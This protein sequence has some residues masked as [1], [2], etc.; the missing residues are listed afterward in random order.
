ML[1]LDQ[2]KDFRSFQER[3]QSAPERGSE[4]FPKVSMKHRPYHDWLRQYP[5]GYPLTEKD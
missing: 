3:F 4:Y 2:Q 5:E 1:Q